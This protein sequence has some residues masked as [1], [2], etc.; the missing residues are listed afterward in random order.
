MRSR[1]CSNLSSA[2]AKSRQVNMTAQ[3]SQHT[4]A[5]LIGYREVLLQGTPATCLLLAVLNSSFIN[6]P[7]MAKDVCDAQ[8]KTGDICLCKLS[9]LHPTQ[10]SVGM[11]EVRI[12]AKKLKDEIQGRSGPDFLNYLRKHNKVEPIVIGPGGIF[13]ITDHHHLARA[14]YDLGETT[15]YCSVVDKLPDAKLDVF[16]KYMEDNNKV[17][18][19]DHNG[20]VITPRDLPTSIKDLRND[21]FRSLAGEVRKFCGLDK[22]DK[23]SSR[24]DYLEFRWADY[25]RERWAQTGIAPEEIDRKFDSASKAA[26]RLAA[27]KEAASLPGYT[28]RISC[29]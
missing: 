19:E 2:G 9:E 28:G 21:P 27:Q 3:G 22:D 26:L 6:W 16:W 18:L 1:G 29:D 5:L 24:E 25:L 15:T 4:F 13:Y 20:N 17:H 10:A 7:A 14:L 11:A 8:S 12:K 23:G